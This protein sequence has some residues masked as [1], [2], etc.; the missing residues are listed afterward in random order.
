[1]EAT[2]NNIG[3]HLKIRGNWGKFKYEGAYKISWGFEKEM[4]QAFRG[5]VTEGCNIRFEFSVT[6][7]FSPQLH[8]NII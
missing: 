3:G 5:P 7:C 2:K 4:G 1:M 8:Q 6:I